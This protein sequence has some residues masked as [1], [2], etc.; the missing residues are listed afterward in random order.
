MT[1]NLQRF[2]FKSSGSVRLASSLQF[3]PR[4]CCLAGKGDCGAVNTKRLFA[5][6]ALGG[7]ACGITVELVQR[8]LETARLRELAKRGDANAQTALAVRYQNGYYGLGIDQRRSLIWIRLAASQQHARAQ[9]IL[10]SMYEN[11][12]GELTKNDTLGN[13]WHFQAACNG[14]ALAQ[15]ITGYRETSSGNNG[16]VWYE[17]AAAQGMP[18][19]QCKLGQMYEHGL[20]GLEKDLAIA[21]NWYR[22]AAALGLPIAQCKLGQMYEDGLGGLEKNLVIAAKWYQNA[23]DQDYPIAQFVVGMNYR[24]GFGNIPKNDALAKIWLKRAALQGHKA[25]QSALGKMK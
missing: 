3:C 12:Y 16:A 23:A 18:I 22:R 10:G 7:L 8:A 25:A 6:F 17:R 19:A 4:G 21:A 24:Q 9:L 2:S 11:G 15:Y 20:G 14:D 1:I 13:H 5:I